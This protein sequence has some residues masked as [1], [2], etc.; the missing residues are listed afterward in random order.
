MRRRAAGNYLSDTPP[1]P[2]QAAATATTPEAIYYQEPVDVASASLQL[3]GTNI[4]PLTPESQQRATTAV[5]LAVGQGVV[6]DNVTVV[7]QVP[8]LRCLLACCCRRC[9][10]RQSQQPRR[11]SVVH[12]P[13]R[14]LHCF[15]A[16]LCSTLP[17]TTGTCEPFFPQAPYTHMAAASIIL[18]RV[19]GM[20][21]V[22]ATL[23]CRIEAPATASS[24][25]L[26][27]LEAAARNGSLA[28]AL[29]AQGLQLSGL[30]AT[31]FRL[32]LRPL[33]T[34][35]EPPNT[36]TRLSGKSRSVAQLVPRWAVWALLA[37]SVVIS[38][39][40]IG[41]P[42]LLLAGAL[43]AAEAT[44]HGAWPASWRLMIAACVCY[45]WMMILLS[46][47]SGC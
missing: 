47:H 6:A 9:T 33:L 27:S 19:Q 10:P 11:L 44:R 32:S 43:S 8:T 7:A 23:A 29:Q 15:R 18:P 36:V 2:T 22:N 31:G 3:Q 14:T 28:S 13:V 24:A 37:S 39:A 21:G 12:M 38:I 40:V 4:L 1:Q 46:R 16:C 35:S 41:K 25:V 20:P 5:A 34:N 45:T 42:S 26:N 30:A 17:Y